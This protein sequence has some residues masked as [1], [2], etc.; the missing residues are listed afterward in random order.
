MNNACH[1]IQGNISIFTEDGDNQED[2]INTVREIIKQS[3]DQDVLVSPEEGIVKV[4]YIGDSFGFGNGG[5]GGNSGTGG[6]GQGN[7]DNNTDN[8]GGI[9]DGAVDSAITNTKDE[10]TK[11]SAGVIIGSCLAILLVLIAFI[12][13]RRRREEEEEVDEGPF[14]LTVFPG[15]YGGPD[16]NDLGKRCICQDV[17]QCKS[18]TCYCYDEDAHPVSFVASSKDPKA[19]DKSKK[20]LTP[21]GSFENPLRFLFGSKSEDSSIQKS[22]SECTDEFY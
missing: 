14:G 1:V 22:N 9:G 4:T 12:V 5:T 7:T 16:E 6:S 3:M 13:I 10:S 11:M 17:K 19:M 15:L 20:A 2:V 18:Q 21:F 8:V